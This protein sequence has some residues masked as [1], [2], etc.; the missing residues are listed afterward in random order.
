MIILF[1]LYKRLAS[2]GMLAAGVRDFKPEEEAC[3]IV[4]MPAHI[5]DVL[6]KLLAVGGGGT[7]LS[8]GRPCQ[9]LRT[10]LFCPQQAGAV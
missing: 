1:F 4:V 6:G 3:F 9:L 5:D 2:I 10:K 7:P 8:P